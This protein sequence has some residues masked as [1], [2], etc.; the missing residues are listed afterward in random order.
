[1]D[2]SMTANFRIFVDHAIE[3]GHIDVIDDS[4]PSPNGGDTAAGVWFPAPAR[5]PSRPTTSAAWPPRAAPGRAGSR[6]STSSSRRTTPPNR[7]TTWR[8]SPS[9][10]SGLAAADVRDP[11]GCWVPAEE[12]RQARRIAEVAG[13]A[14]VD[15]VYLA[16]LVRDMGIRRT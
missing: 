5:C 10:Q 2:G 1:M 7:T 9:G 14:Y 4:V 8:C 11:K 13:L 3:H 12:S 6:S 15:G 16:D